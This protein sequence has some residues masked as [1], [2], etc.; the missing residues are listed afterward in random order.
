[1]RRLLS[2]CC[3]L[4]C[5]T[6]IGI[7][8]HAA[9]GKKLGGLGIR[10]RRAYGPLPTRSQNPLLLQSLALPMESATTRNKKQI[11]TE[12]QTTFSNAYEFSGAGNTRLALDMEIWRTVLAQEYGLA[13]DVDL[14]LE[15]P[16]I[17]NSGGFLDGFIQGYHGFLGAPNGGREKVAN[18]QHQFFMRQNGRTLFNHT[19]TPLGLSDLS[20]RA[21]WQLNRRFLQK[22][23]FD[24]AAAFA[25]KLP[26]GAASR[27][28]GSGHVDLGFSFFAEKALGRFHFVSQA[29]AVF[30]TGHDALDPVVS[31]TVFQFGQSAEFQIKDGW[32]VIAQLTGS[33]PNFK[34][35]DA[36]ALKG[37]AV[38]LTIGFAGSFPIRSGFCDEY[39]YKFGFSEDI[40]AQGPA[41]DFSLLFL[42]GVRY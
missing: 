17:T 8:A 1:M 9:S 26:T 22:L 36:K 29:G 40:T 27:G 3:F 4:L 24:L 21:K 32:S 18:G 42:T 39:Y 15:V 6:N 38:D 28:L 11:A 31:K 14:R 33:A 34:N 30:L 5:L 19:K 41:V 35:V 13:D 20:L 7:T 2:I 12:L 23:P 10:D 16:F 37:P 25:I